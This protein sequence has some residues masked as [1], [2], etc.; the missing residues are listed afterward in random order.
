MNGFL[1]LLVSLVLGMFC[2]ALLLAG[3]HAYRHD[4][5]TFE[6][7]TSDAKQHYTSH[8]NNLHVIL[9]CTKD[10]KIVP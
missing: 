4:S 6:C 1:A 7:A 10:G 2:A 3:L 8:D 5:M 9:W